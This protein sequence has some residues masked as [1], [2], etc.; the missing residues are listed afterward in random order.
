MMQILKNFTFSLY[1]VFSILLYSELF[2][3]ELKRNNFMPSKDDYILEARKEVSAQFVEIK[4]I[5]YRRLNTKVG[6]ILLVDVL[7][8]TPE[9][10]EKSICHP[11]STNKK[12]VIV[13][14]KR[15][16]DD[17]EKTIAL[18]SSLIVQTVDK[19]CNGEY[20]GEAYIDP[21]FD[22]ETG[23]TIK[24]KGRDANTYKIYNKNF[25]PNIN[26]KAEF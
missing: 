8:I 5:R 22:F 26:F 19:K 16:S 14:K 17:D 7:K 4:G 21:N 12:D 23:I 24:G 25:A 9:D 3:E 20:D 15:L 10:I 11:S 2:A 1:I 13:T 18:Y 6:S